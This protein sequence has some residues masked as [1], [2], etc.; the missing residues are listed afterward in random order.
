MRARRGR[1]G[2]ALVEF[3]LTA[4]VFLLLLMGVVDLGR[5]IYYYS[6]IDQAAAEGARVAIRD[7][8][9]LP[10]NNAVLTAVKTHAVDVVLANPCPNGPIPTG[11]PSPNTG[12][13]YITEP[14]PSSTIETTQPYPMDAPGGQVPPKAATA[15]CSAVNPASGHMPLTVTIVYNFVPL[16]PLISQ[17][18]ADHILLTVSVTYRTEY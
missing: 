4:P 13:V 6:T 9:L 18:A 15:S 14:N 16:T 11:R 17:A 8:P 2:Q 5:V 12:W 10:N 3:A 1:R 7:S